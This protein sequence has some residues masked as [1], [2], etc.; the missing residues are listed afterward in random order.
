LGLPEGLEAG[1]YRIV[2]T[3]A[4]TYLRDL[5]PG[6]PPLSTSPVDFVRERVVYADIF[7][8]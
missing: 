6:D 7:E 8:L 1:S 5:I 2:I 4:E 3:E